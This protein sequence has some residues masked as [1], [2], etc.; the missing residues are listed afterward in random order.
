MQLGMIVA[1][2]EADA[3][4]AD[5]GDSGRL[6]RGVRTARAP[7]AVLPDPGPVF[8]LGNGAGDVDMFSTVRGRVGAAFDRTFVYMTGGL[9]WA[10]RDDGSHRV[11]PGPGFFVP[12]FARFGR[13]VL[14][15]AR[16]DD[17]S[18]FGFVVGG[19]IEYAVT[20][21]IS[22]K[23]EG[24]YVDFGTGNGSRIAGVTN[25]GLPVRG[26]GEGHDRSAFGSVRAGLNF[27]FGSL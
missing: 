23:M 5:L 14:R 19:G 17:G 2:L 21:S 24:L 13:P 9:A 10:P 26:V 15:R 27:R 20:D 16:N 11:D 1:G 7:G 3:Q 22:A 18:D 12:G 6:V 25:L 8:L 4:A